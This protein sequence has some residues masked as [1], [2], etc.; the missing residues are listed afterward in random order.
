MAGVLGILGLLLYLVSLV[1]W[2]MILIHAFKTGGALHGILCFCIWP[3]AVYW[4]FAK[5]EHEKKNMIIGGLL[6]GF[7]VGAA[8]M[9]LQV[10]MA[11]G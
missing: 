3:Y 9:V 6:G 7:A 8:L 10:M 11:Q 5:F 1:C 4:G 2:V